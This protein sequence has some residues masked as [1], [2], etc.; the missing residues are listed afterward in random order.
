VLLGDGTT[1]SLPD[2]EDNQA[3]YPQPTVQKPGL[4]FPLVRLVVLFSLATGLLHEVA[5]GPYAGKETGEPALLRE[6]FERLKAGDVLVA[7]RC[8]CGWFL[9]ALLQALGVDVV[10]RLHQMREADFQKGERLGK[11]DHLVEWPRPPKPDWMDAAAYARMP[12]SLRLREVQVQVAERG[13]RVQSLVVV[14]TL[15]D[16][17][18]YPADELAT[19]YRRRWLVEL[20]VRTL[21]ST[22]KLD[23]LRCKTPD[24]ARKELRTGL[25]AYNLLRQTMLQA[26][27]A[28]GRCPRELSFTVALQTIAAAWMVA[29]ITETHQELLV[30]LRLAHMG[31]H[32]IGNRPNRTEPRATHR[33]SRSSSR[34]VAG[35][36]SDLSPYAT[37]GSAI[38]SRMGLNGPI[39]PSA[40]LPA[41]L[42]RSDQFD[43]TRLL[44]SIY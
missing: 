44:E 37:T 11:G 5:M 26:A 7:D 13:F 41:D 10:V 18:T 36:P 17:T 12:A 14:T 4:G 21:K 24:M 1:I 39:T 2:T 29:V 31:S 27:I 8:Y 34:E 25:L 19:L 23:V 43:R 42:R 9:I 22:L 3:S 20:D 30:Q 6:M 32:R 40:S 33:T 38:R 28:A 35:Q 15:L 16:S